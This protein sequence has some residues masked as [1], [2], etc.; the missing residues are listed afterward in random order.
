MSCLLTQQMSCLLTQQMSCLQTQQMSCLQTHHIVEMPQPGFARFG[1]QKW[2]SVTIWTYRE[3]SQRKSQE[4]HSLGEADPAL[5]APGL[6][7]TT[8]PWEARVCGV[9]VPKRGGWLGLAKNETGSRFPERFP[10]LLGLACP[11]S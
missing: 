5:V 9:P 10:T 7:D 6:V 4:W 1:T 11:M 2:K 8:F 3:I